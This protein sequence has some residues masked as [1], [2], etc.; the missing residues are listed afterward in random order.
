MR[1]YAAPVHRAWLQ[2]A[3]VS[4]G[5]AEAAAVRCTHDSALALVVTLEGS[6]G[7]LEGPGAASETTGGGAGLA[8]PRFSRATPPQPSTTLHL[9]LTNFFI[10]VHPTYQSKFY[11]ITDKYFSRYY[12]ISLGAK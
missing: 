1:G 7:V 2:H 5:M 8:P 4:H 3:P 6:R 9:H 12:L 11:S 10:L